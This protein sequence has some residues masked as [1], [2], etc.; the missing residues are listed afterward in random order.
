MDE[1][2]EYFFTEFN[3]NFLKE[4]W[5]IAI[6]FRGDENLI[7]QLN[8]IKEINRYLKTYAIL[9]DGLENYIPKQ[10]DDLSKL[11]NILEI[12]QECNNSSIHSKFKLYLDFVFISIVNSNKYN[13]ESVY[14]IEIENKIISA[15][16][17]KKRKRL[18][19]KIISFGFA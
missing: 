5:I 10:I 12:I 2:N 1:Q 7:N 9:E 14:S 16:K 18:F 3:K 11:F 13:Y 4:K 17:N 8:A 15:V 19:R 6:Q